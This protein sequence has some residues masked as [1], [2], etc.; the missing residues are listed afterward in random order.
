M[1]LTQKHWSEGQF[2]N[3]LEIIAPMADLL[4]A[5]LGS[6]AVMHRHAFE[7]NQHVGGVHRLPAAFGMDREWLNVGVDAQCAQWLRPA[8]R[9]PV[10]RK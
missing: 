6:P 10:T 1:S 4:V 9:A 2:C 7:S 8:T 5:A 3:E